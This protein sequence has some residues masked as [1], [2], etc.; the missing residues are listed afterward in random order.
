MKLN[1]YEIRFTGRK[2][3][4]IGKFYPITAQRFAPS[5]AKAIEALADQF[6]RMPPPPEVKQIPSPFDCEWFERVIRNDE[7]TA[8]VISVAV[9]SILR[10]CERLRD[11]T[12][13]ESKA[14]HDDPD[15]P[16]HWLFHAPAEMQIPAAVLIKAAAEVVLYHL[17]ETPA[18]REIFNELLLA[19]P[20][21]E[22]L[23]K[24]CD[25]LNPDC[26]TLGP[27]MM[28]T[29]KELATKALE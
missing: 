16:D 18:G 10:A 29:L 1:T 22:R 12:A 20:A 13:A 17:R 6:E 27:G 8:S 14:W 2:L 23:A 5:P 4:A 25:K 7:P 28:A 19:N 26:L 15:A 3:G 11:K 24:E 9:S 21:A